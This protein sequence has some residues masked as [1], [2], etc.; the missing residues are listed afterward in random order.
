M[1][2]ASEVFRDWNIDGDPSSGRRQLKLFEIRQWGEGIEAVAGSPAAL[3][4]V[5][6]KV[7]LSLAGVSA[8]RRAVDA[9]TFVGWPA[10]TVDTVAGPRALAARNAAFLPDGFALIAT[11]TGTGALAVT[12]AVMN[13]TLLQRERDGE[14]II[15]VGS[16]ASGVTGRLAA[17]V[18]RAIDRAALI[19]PLSAYGMGASE[20]MA[21]DPTL[22][23]GRKTRVVTIAGWYL[24]QTAEDAVT[25]RVTSASCT[26]DLT[27]L[28]DGRSAVIHA[29]NGCRVFAGAAAFAS[30]A[31]NTATFTGAAAFRVYRMDTAAIVE[32]IIGTPAYS[33]TTKPAA[34]RSILHAGQSH[35]ELGCAAGLLGGFA[36]ALL[37]GTLTGGASTAE[38]HHIVAGASNSAAVRTSSNTR[39]WWDSVAGTPGPHLT[40]AIAAIS[41]AVTAG[42]P[43]PEAMIWRL[44]ET[45]AP[46]LSG[47]TTTF[48]AFK[49]G[50]LSIWQRLRTEAPGMRVVVSPPGSNDRPISFSGMMGVRSAYR[51]LAAE[52][53]TWVFLGQEMYDLPRPYDGVHLTDQGYYAAGI[54]DA[55]S[56]R[57]AMGATIAMG[58]EVTAAVLQADG[59]VAVTVS[60]ATGVTFPPAEDVGPYPYGLCIV[61]HAQGMNAHAPIMRATATVNG[62]TSTAEIILY[63]AAPVAGMYLFTVPG[64]FHEVRRRSYIRDNRWHG[65]SPGLPMRFQRLG[66]L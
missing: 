43:L 39:Y 40:D 59:T 11:L 38:T 16:S 31:G 24:L 41:A 35:T 28:P 57:R 50:V 8:Y 34:A 18:T 55:M 19:N 45:D 29:P 51:E 56:Y 27:R 13:A 17:Q 64:W 61:N 62:A 20:T 60:M 63:P 22:E 66:P 52:N 21:L 30:G 12:Q 15:L 42:Q 37:D 14:I 25:I 44:G 65:R 36:D 7:P 49:A 33:T 6:A 23:T 3:D 5:A 48:A 26:V 4:A 1:P 9:G 53:P 10:S 46:A 32:P 54:R 47:G 2:D 58:P